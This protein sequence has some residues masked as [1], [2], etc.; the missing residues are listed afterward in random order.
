[1][2]AP[3]DIKLQISKTSNLLI[4]FA[5]VV[6]AITVL[7]G[8]YT[9]YINYFWK[10]NILVQ[11]VDFT[12]G[13]ARLKFGS[14]TIDLEG[15]ATFLLGGDWG[16]RFGSVYNNGVIEYTRIELVRKDMVYEYIQK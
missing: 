12:N 16:V 4:K 11:E 2:Q 7:A 9:F 1:M 15:D 3:P 13:I 10:P 5:A 8:G 14:K 6:G